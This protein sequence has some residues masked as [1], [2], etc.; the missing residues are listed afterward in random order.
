MHFQH[1]GKQRE[2]GEKFFEGRVGIRENFL[3]T[4]F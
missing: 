1:D 4:E 3:L 2:V